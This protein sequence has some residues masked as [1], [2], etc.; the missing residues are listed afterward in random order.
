MG[1][2]NV[3]SKDDMRRLKEKTEKWMKV[4]EETAKQKVSEAEEELKRVL[5]ENEKVRKALGVAPEVALVRDEPFILDEVSQ[6]HQREG[7][8]PRSSRHKHIH[9]DKVLGPF[10][11]PHGPQIC[12]S[13]EA[14][15]IA[16]L[17]KESEELRLRSALLRDQ[18]SRLES[19]H[20]MD[21]EIIEGLRLEMQ[22]AITQLDVFRTRDIT[23]RVHS[24]SACTQCSQLGEAY[25]PLIPSIAPRDAETQNALPTA[26]RRAQPPSNIL[27]PKDAENPKATKKKKKAAVM[28]TPVEPVLFV[29]PTNSQEPSIQSYQRKMYLLQVKVYSRSAVDVSDIPWPVFPLARK[30]YPI[31]IQ[32]RKDIKS[33]G[34]MEFAKA[35]WIGGDGLAEK[36]AGEMIAAW[37]WMCAAGRVQCT[38]DLRSWIE[39]TTTFLRHAR[40][41]LG[42]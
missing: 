12:D 37:S 28:P 5:E 1:T 7:N 11:V 34:V 16:S 4:R 35:F 19:A 3:K 29:D 21:R 14:K 9:D 27:P 2:L 20:Q 18:N 15:R 42:L 40:E 8:N 6:D 33:A 17:E 24:A 23:D 26:E 32:G 38:K 36:R 22:E 25:V 41:K 30:A 39:R 13:Q 31:V 10:E